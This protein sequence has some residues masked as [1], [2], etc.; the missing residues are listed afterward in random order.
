MN[1]PALPTERDRDEAS[2]AYLISLVTL[3]AG[4][5]LPVINLI[6]ML[7]YYF[8]VRKRSSFVQFHCFQALTSQSAIVL[9]NAVALFWTIRIIFYGVSFTPYYFGYLFTIFIFNLVDFIFNII[10]AIK[11]K[12]GEYYYFT[13]FGKLAVAMGYT[14]KIKG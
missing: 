8:N 3:I 1:N 6:V 9:L 4:L 5:P 13:F 11:A 7:I 14:R 12:K 2:L 10:A